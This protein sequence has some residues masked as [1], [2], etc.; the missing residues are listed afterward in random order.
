MINTIATI[1]GTGIAVGSA[2][3]VV[4]SGFY[5]T[6]KEADTDHQA[7]E[8]KFDSKLDK[9]ETRLQHEIE[10]G[11]KDVKSEFKTIADKIDEMKTRYVTNENFKTYVDSISQLLKM[12]SDRMT[13]METTLDD[14]RDDINTVIRSR[15]TDHFT[16]P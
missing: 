11:N 3:G 16:N 13:R 1:I 15:Q 5:K 7:I 6:H 10:L 2:T 9:L 4:L 14:I 12:T 8:K